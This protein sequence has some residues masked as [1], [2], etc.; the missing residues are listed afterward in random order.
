MTNTITHNVTKAIFPVAGLGTRFLPAT[1]AIPKEM[2]P[3]VDRPLLQYVVEEAQ[4]AGI[5]D[6]L[7][8]TGRN[9]RAIED[10]FDTD[11]ELKSTLKKQAKIGLLSKVEATEIPSGHLFYTR[12]YPQLGLGHAVRCAREFVQGEPFA[13]LL[14]D[15]FILA[16]RPC[17]SQLLDVYDRVGGGNVLAVSEV[18]AEQTQNYGIVDILK[19]EE[20]VVTLKGVIEKP[21]PAEAPSCLAIIGRYI[22]Q[23]Q[24]FSYLDQARVGKGN[25]IQLT[26]SIARLLDIQPTYGYRFHG[27]RYD[28]GNQRGYVEANVAYALKHSE[29]FPD[30]LKTIE[31]L[32][33]DATG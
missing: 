14:P 23:P 1:K 21:L 2:L 30:F 6:F 31:A 10:H 32:L 3:I 17:L 18:S 8:I 20:G 5:K 29:L 27:K 15:D 24:I 25:E 19:E 16:D 12:Q 28:C 13:V 22:L 11:A 33:K 26:D 4:E 7:F 9:K